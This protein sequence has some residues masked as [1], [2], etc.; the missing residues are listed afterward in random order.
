MFMTYFRLT[1]ID[2][3]QVQDQQIALFGCLDE[4]LEKK[5][6]MNVKDT[7]PVSGNDSVME[8]LEN[9]FR[10]MNPIHARRQSFFDAMQ[11]RGQS[12]SAFMADLDALA[13]A[14]EL[15]DI[16][17]EQLQVYRLIAGCQNPELRKKIME[18]E[19]EPTMQSLVAT[20]NAYEAARNATPGHHASV[21]TGKSRNGPR[22]GHKKGSRGH[23]RG[24]SRGRSRARSHSANSASS[25]RC[26]RC[27]NSSHTRDKCPKSPEDFVCDKC[28]KT[29]HVKSVCGAGMK[30]NRYRSKS[31][32]R[33]YSPGNNRGRSRQRR[34]SGQRYEGNTIFDGNS[35]STKRLPVQPTPGVE[36]LSSST[37]P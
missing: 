22:R 20:V 4:E 15:A 6:R 28:N 37:S 3:F 1:R 27:G 36:R 35:T 8:E 32:N 11:G 12:M 34:K 13:G 17:S 9:I 23:Q 31:R 19:V 5:V 25:V 26:W 24:K 14:A 30:K 16:S 21:V 29:G 2:S 10:T 33:S 7:T 18:K